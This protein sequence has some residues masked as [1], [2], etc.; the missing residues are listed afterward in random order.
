MKHANPAYDLQEIL[1]FSEP[2]LPQA[3]H[4]G[5]GG[6]PGAIRI[7]VKIQERAG[8]VQHTIAMFPTCTRVPACTSSRALTFRASSRSW[9]EHEREITVETFQTC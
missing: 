7:R 6:R 1:R 9:E 4:R 3:R 5:Q 8:G 2:R